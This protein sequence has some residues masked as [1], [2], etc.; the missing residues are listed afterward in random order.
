M[1]G[2][3]LATQELNLYFATFVLVY[4][5]SANALRQRRYYLDKVGVHPSYDRPGMEVMLGNPG[6]LGQWA[7]RRTHEE[8]VR[9]HRTSEER[10]TCTP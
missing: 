9:A 8:A 2:T 7:I 1:G 3:K 4:G 6:I 5:P 10:T